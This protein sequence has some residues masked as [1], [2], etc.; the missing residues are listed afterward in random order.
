[1]RKYLIVEN[2]LERYPFSTDFEQAKTSFKRYQNDCNTVCMVVAGDG[3]DSTEECM[4]YR[5][6]YYIFVDDAIQEMYNNSGTKKY[7]FKDFTI[8]FEDQ[9][10]AQIR[11]SVKSNNNWENTFV[12]DRSIN[13]KELCGTIAKNLKDSIHSYYHNQMMMNLEQTEKNI[14]PFVGKDFK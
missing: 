2:G 5:G 7:Y 14:A 6:K 10:D 3:I 11:C 1:M 12:L 9:G 13:Y 4:N 8:T